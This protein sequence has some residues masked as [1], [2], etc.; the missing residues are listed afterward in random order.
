MGILPNV[1]GPFMWAT[2]HYICLAAPT[3][4]SDSDKINYKNFFSILPAIMPCQSCGLHLAE[5]Y[6]ILPIDN[7][8]STKDDLFKWSVDLHNLVN[9]QLGKSTISTEDARILWTV[10]Y[11]RLVFKNQTDSSSNMNTDSKSNNSNKTSSIFLKLTII[12]GILIIILLLI[13]YMLMNKL[14]KKIRK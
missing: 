1:F 9:T 14:Y 3:T 2:I 8:L 4:L 10:N 5:N 7:S 11:P 13:I 6:N 12:F